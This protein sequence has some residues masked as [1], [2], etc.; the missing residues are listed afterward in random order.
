MTG[1]IRHRKLFDRRYVPF[2]RRRAY[3]LA[4]IL[5]WSILMFVFVR[6]CVFTAVEIV[7]PSMEPT[8]NSGERRILKRWVYA[9]GA[10]ARGDII[11]INRMNNGELAV[12]RI[13][14]LPGET[15]HLTRQGVLIDGQFLEEPYLVP[16][17]ES[18]ASRYGYEPLAID[19]GHYFVMGDNRANSEDSRYFGPLPETCILGPLTP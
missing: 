1:S 15:I 11:A 2:E 4:C 8:L 17:T 3:V 12:K 6:G 9:T 10:P 16:G 13:V 18:V 14:G 7:G 19:D 5:F